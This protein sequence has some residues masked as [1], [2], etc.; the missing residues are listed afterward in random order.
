MSNLEQIKAQLNDI[1]NQRIKYSTLKEQALNK[2]AEIEQ[3]YGVKSLEELE[4]L[5]QKAQA[6]YEKS[7]LSAQKYIE[8][9]NK[10]FAGYNGVL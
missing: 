7:V 1:N 5:V 9:T 10:I 4:T 3:K 6:E 8:D 2:C